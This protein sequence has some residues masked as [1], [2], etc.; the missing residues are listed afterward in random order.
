MKKL[1][2]K[3]LFTILT[4]F[5]IIVLPFY[6]L[7]AVFFSQIVGITNAGFFI[8]EF[9]II[10]L[11]FSLIY[12][13]VKNKKIP[14]FDT[15]DYLIFGYI[16]YGIIITFINGLGLDSIFYGGRYDFIFFI[17]FLIYK[18]GNEFLQVKN[19]DL[20]KLLLI[21]GGLSI[22]FS[23]MIKF[24]LGEQTLISFGFTDYVSNWTFSGKI[25]SYHGLE[26][27]GIKR[28]QGIF[29]G[30]NQMAFYLI[31]YT[32]IMMHYL[33][34][35]FEYHII[36][37]LIFLFILLFIT[38][39]RSALLGV[40]SGSGLLILLNIK[41]IYKNHK[42]I[43]INV[44]TSILI[45][46]G[47]LLMIFSDR[48]HNIFFRTSSTTGHFDRM[49]IG[50]DRF[51]EKPLGAG[52]A[53]SGPAYRSIY[54]DKQTKLDEQYYIPESWFIQQLVEGGII[55]FLL[56]IFILVNILNR[57]Y[58][59]SKSIF[60]GLIAILVMNIFLHIFEATY[61]SILLFIFVGLIYNK[62]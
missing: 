18:H 52:L 38:Y 28:F 48:V 30:P 12:E 23:L 34:K 29:D 6:V 15:I 60:V 8:K 45:I 14:Q 53:E 24:R 16:F 1:L 44:I 21:S 3:N 58:T 33:K 4:Q 13:F 59:N 9:I 51:L 55:Y 57:L 26:N 31:F 43:L 20:C 19:K 36:L 5:L 39:S 25:P 61:L 46:T 35:K 10:L 22:M 32:S 7:I 56:F 27:S 17:V 41:T 37:V 11:A 50:I 42:K 54:P 40:V 62:K 47:I 2:E 49:E